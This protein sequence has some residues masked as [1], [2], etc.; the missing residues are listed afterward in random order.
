MV[1]TF[2]CNCRPHRKT[3]NLSSLLCP[4][5]LQSRH[6][7]RHDMKRNAT[8][9]TPHPAPHTPHPTPHTPHPTP[10]PTTPTPTTP[11]H[12]HHTTTPPFALCP[13]LLFLS[14]VRAALCPALLYLMGSFLGCLVPCFLM[15][16]LSGWCFVWLDLLGS[17][18]ADGFSCAFLGHF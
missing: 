9:R 18:G 4:D 10:T 12:H 3:P 11:P 15:G 8:H 1:A 13:S 6:T 2:V 7:T 14:P 16:S 17:P 5:K